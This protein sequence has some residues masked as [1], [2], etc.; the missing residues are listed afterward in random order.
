LLQESVTG[1]SLGNLSISSYR[2]TVNRSPDQL[3]R[4]SVE[5]ECGKMISDSQVRKLF[6]DLSQHGEEVW[7][8]E[9]QLMFGDDLAK[10][11]L[12][13]REESLQES[14]DNPWVRA[15]E[16]DL[17]V[18]NAEGLCLVSQLLTD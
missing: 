15:E 8:P 17:V 1:K 7:A 16:C 3:M 6:A 13:C 9:P 4:V 14:S 12:L 11:M 5:A 10:A 18:S 2:Y